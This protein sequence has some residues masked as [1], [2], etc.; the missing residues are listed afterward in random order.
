MVVVVL[1]LN[2]TPRRQVKCQAQLP[3]W[4]RIVE[5]RESKA[6]ALLM[7]LHDRR[8]LRFLWTLHRKHVCVEE[9]SKT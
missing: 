8:A 7:A 4:G 2:F 3:K 6:K 5:N 1:R 9:A